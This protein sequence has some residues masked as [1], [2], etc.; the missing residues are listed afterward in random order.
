MER[1]ELLLLVE[2][3]LAK[4][5]YSDYSDGSED[6]EIYFNPTTL[7]F[8]KNKSSEVEFINILTTT[9]FFEGSFESCIINELYLIQKQNGI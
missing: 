8:S 9:I 4:F 1:L 2:I 6:V 3:S 7:E 5:D